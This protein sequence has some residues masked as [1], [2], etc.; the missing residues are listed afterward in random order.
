MTSMQW[1]RTE[2][3]KSL[4]RIAAVS[5]IAAAVLFFTTH[6]SADASGDD[7]GRSSTPTDPSAIAATTF[8][9]I[10]VGGIADGGAACG[11]TPGAPRN[12]TFDA[13][14]LAG[15]P[16]D[17]SVSVRFGSPNHTWAG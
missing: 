13:I 1:T 10:G 5:F 8:S 4:S 6:R 15:S 14:G 2:V 3:S 17:V 11:P 7:V 16:T 9:G 12:V